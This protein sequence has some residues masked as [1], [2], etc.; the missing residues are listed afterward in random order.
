MKVQYN[1]S[2][3]KSKIRVVYSKKLGQL[4]SYLVSLFITVK[5]EVRLLFCSEEQCFVPTNNVKSNI[6]GFYS[7]KLGELRSNVSLFITSKERFDCCNFIKALSTRNNKLHVVYLTY[8]IS[9]LYYFKD[10]RR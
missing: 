5:D 7:R 1:L 8:G 9:Y 10:D 6:R 4:R 2:S 3:E